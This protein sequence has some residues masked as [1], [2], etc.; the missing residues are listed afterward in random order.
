MLFGFSTSSSVPR[1]VAA[2]ARRNLWVLVCSCALGGGCSSAPEKDAKEAAAVHSSAAKAELGQWGVETRYFSDAINPGDDFY[3]YVNEGWLNASEIPSGLSR[4]SSFNLLSLEVED[5][6]QDIIKE[7]ASQRAARNTPA[8]KLANLYESYTR[9]GLRNTMGLTMFQRDISDILLAR[10]ARAISALMG[11]VGYPS[12]VDASVTLD[13]DNPKAYRVA[14]AQGGLGLPGRDYYLKNEE[15]YIGHRQAYR[16]YLKFLLTQAGFSDPGLKADRVLAFEMQLAQQQWAPEQQRDVLRMHRVMSM[17]ELQSF[18]PDFAWSRYFRSAGIPEQDKLIV[19]TDTAV[20]ANAKLFAE[21]DLDTLKCY[22]IA[23]L[24]NRYA[25]YLTEQIE[26]KQ[27]ELYGHRLNGIDQPR[28]L[29]VRG[30]NFVDNYLGEPL[31]KLYVER[32]FPPAHKAEMETLVDYVRQA[33]RLRL[34]TNPW[35]DGVTRAQA[36]HKLAAFNTKIGYPQQWHDYSSLEISGLELVDNIRRIER[37]RHREAL[38]RLEE[39]RRDWEWS[40]TPQTVNAYYSALRNEIVFPAAI[41]QPPFFDPKADPA[42]NFGAIGMVIGHELGHGFDDQGSRFD[43]TGALRNWWTDAARTNFE[44]F[45]QALVDQYS[46][47]SPIDGLNVNGQLT[48]GENIGDLGGLGIAFS[49]WKLYEQEHYPGEGAPVLNGF[50]G[51]QRFF[52]SYAQMWRSLYKDEALRWQLTSR[53][54]SPAEFR[55]NGVLRNF[56]PWYEAF[57][58]D[59]NAALYLPKEQRVSIW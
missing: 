44:T 39:G 33:F 2:K 22:T 11:R 16:E 18:A 12:V 15:P 4:Y 25:P 14:V 1:S 35:M 6:I 26:A 31:G 52:L 7:S 40:M 51:D 19:G 23:H 46:V 27:F 54:H 17:T 34:K 20:Q 45:T 24:L 57:G 32:H 47:Y 30:V 37:W 48:L 8:H 55:V 41:L 28:P 58:I 56:D 5:Q 21:T 9:V 36:Q 10:D 43:G 53:P 49:A 13:P 3:R 50:T 29:A 59:E 42:V 38:N